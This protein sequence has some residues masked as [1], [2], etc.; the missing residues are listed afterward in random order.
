MSNTVRKLRF[1]HIILIFMG[2][3][4]LI[5]STIGFLTI[6][7]FYNDPNAEVQQA[8]ILTK[9]VTGLCYVASFFPIGVAV[10]SYI[11]GEEQY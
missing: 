2:C 9:I 4:G 3:V 8:L 11:Q 6:Q 5:G 7:H 10:R 1:D